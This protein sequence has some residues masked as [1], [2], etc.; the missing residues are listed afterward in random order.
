MPVEKA[1]FDSTWCDSPL[2]TTAT[3]MEAIRSEGGISKVSV[4]L[5]NAYV[6]HLAYPCIRKLTAVIK[7]LP[8]IRSQLFEWLVQKK[9]S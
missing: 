2:V 4:T 1:S 7:R 9:Q 3:L 8:D 6:N 5:V